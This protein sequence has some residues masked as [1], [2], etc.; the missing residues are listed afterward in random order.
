MK[1][2]QRRVRGAV[3]MGIT[4]AVAW[5]AAGLAI[6]VAS[7][8][9]PNSAFGR[10]FEVF[11]A[12]L[13]AHHLKA[14]LIRSGADYARFASSRDAPERR[15]PITN[16]EGGLGIVAGVSVD[17]LVVAVSAGGAYGP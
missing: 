5:V 16:V 13:P 10:F 17:S 6:G 1:R 2:W 8:L 12:P 9:M 14:S 4:W 11:D 7:I 3:G 15:E